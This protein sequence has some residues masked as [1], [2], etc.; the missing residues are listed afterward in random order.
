MNDIK[1]TILKTN[2]TGKLTTT[3][4]KFAKLV[5]VNENCVFNILN[6]LVKE[7]FLDY[8]IIGDNLAIQIINKEE[9]KAE[10]QKVI[11]S[12]VIIC[13][14]CRYMTNTRYSSEVINGVKYKKASCYCARES[15][16]IWEKKSCKNFK[17]KFVR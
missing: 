4:A 5:K 11:E 7:S 16:P 10:N 2:N 9:F 8:R 3:I 6:T 17:N 1:N 14:K 13:I 12:N 15:N